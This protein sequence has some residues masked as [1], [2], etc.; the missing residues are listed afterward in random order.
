MMT[1][2]PQSKTT[3]VALIVRLG[4]TDDLHPRSGEQVHQTVR[5]RNYTS[6]LGQGGSSSQPDVGRQSPRGDRP[7]PRLYAL[8][9]GPLTQAGSSNLWAPSWP[10]I[11]PP[12]D[13]SEQEEGIQPTVPVLPSTDTCHIFMKR[14]RC[15]YWVFA[16]TL[17]ASIVFP[18]E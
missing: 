10:R 1:V 2:T 5:R 16:L 11:H 8:L 3:V 7:Y 4:R 14:G 13:S 9:F 6:G 12:G 17:S 18:V 15:N